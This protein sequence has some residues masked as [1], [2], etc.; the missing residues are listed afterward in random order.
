MRR[1]ILPVLFVCLA[2]G[3]LPAFEWPVDRIVLTSTFAEHRGDHFHAGIDLGGG[4]QPIY[5]IS[6]G[7]LVFSYREGRDYSSLPTGL[8]NFLVLQHQG[9]VRSLY[10]HLAAGSMDPE[11]RIHD[12]SRPLGTIGS[13]GYSSGKH[14]HLT[15]IDTEM[16]TI[17]NPLLLLPPLPD[18]QPPEIKEVFI[19]SGEQ[20]IDLENLMSVGRAEVELFA[21]VYDLREDVSFLWKLAPYKVF[22]SQDGREISAFTFDSL[23]SAPEEG[24]ASR[25]LL[26]ANTDRDFE[27]IFDSPWTLSLGRINLVPGETSLTV[28]ASD[29]AGNES[30][31]EYALTVLE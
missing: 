12:R 13:S 6:A 22:L 25:R 17:I 9:G 21:T 18:G 4:E 2:G 29:F 7:E 14:L 23:R 10:A 11:R 3:G 26:L 1:L 30:F 20:R 15:I 31:K 5:P 27:D 19:R 28:F 24:G 16:G 8:G